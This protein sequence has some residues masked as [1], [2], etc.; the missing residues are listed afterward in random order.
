MLGP[1]EKAAVMEVLDGPM[2]VHGYRTKAFEIAFSD[3]VGG[4]SWAVAV[5]SCTAALHLALLAHGVGNGDEVIVPAQT[6]IATAHSVE[7]CHAKP[8]FVDAEPET[9]NIDISQIDAKITDRTKAISI[10]HYL[11]MPVDM[12]AVNVIALR[13]GLTVIEDAALAIGSRYKNIH[14]G[15]LGDVGCFSFYPV[16]HITTAEGGMIVTR[17]EDIANDAERRRAFGMDRTVTERAMPGEYDVTI[18]GT[19]YRMNELEAAIGLEQLKKVGAW[20]VTRRN[21]H[22]SLSAGLR[23]IEGVRL[24]SSSHGEFESSYYCMAVLLEDDLSDKRAAVM[25]RLKERGVGTSIYYPAA[26]PL[27]TYYRNK[28]GYG[29]GDFPVAERISRTSIA[30][31]VGPHL[32][33]T[34]MDYIIDEFKAAIADA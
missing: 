29:E 4:D 12:D 23:E 17:H 3:F 2:L 18:L 19:N 21:N 1:E 30:L 6:H 8:I 11:G 22:E 9:G 20:L 32:D 10:V 24:F 27:M 28:Y 31:P 34:D 33:C 16:K 13:Y 5:N 26:V 25:T 14:A 7:Y 15:L